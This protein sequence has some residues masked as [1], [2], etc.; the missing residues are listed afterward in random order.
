MGTPFLSPS[1]S[2]DEGAIHVEGIVTPTLGLVEVSRG[3]L[4]ASHCLLSETEQPSEN[5]IGQ[6]WGIIIATKGNPV[7]C[8][9]G[10]DFHDLQFCDSRCMGLL[11]KLGSECQDLRQGECGPFVFSYDNGLVSPLEPSYNHGRRGEISYFRQSI[12]KKAL[13]SC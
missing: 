7:L 2:S 8:E 12:W 6:R 10:P 13:A 3:F 9:A 11:E 1:A 5:F 4:S